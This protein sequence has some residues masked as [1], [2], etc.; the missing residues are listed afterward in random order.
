MV[1]NQFHN[2]WFACRNSHPVL[3]QS[4]T[5]GNIVQYLTRVWVCRVCHQ[6]G[7]LVIWPAWHFL[8]SCSQTPNTRLTFEVTDVCEYKRCYYSQ[9]MHSY[10]TSIWSHW[11]MWIYEM[12]LQSDHSFRVAPC[13]IYLGCDRLSVQVKFM[14]LISLHV[15]STTPS[16]AIF[17]RAVTDCPCRCNLCTWLVCM[18]LALLHCPVIVIWENNLDVVSQDK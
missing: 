17:T 6:L 11:C 2:A 18:L 3:M 15:A 12:L 10:E 1:R 8:R 5:S 7:E 4:S 9:I 13:S 14:H 16:L